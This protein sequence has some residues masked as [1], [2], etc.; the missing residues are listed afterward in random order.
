MFAIQQRLDLAVVVDL[1][2]V[3]EV[4]A[5][6]EGIPEVA[7][8]S[9]RELVEEVANKVTTTTTTVED[10]EVLVGAEDLV[11][12]IMTSHSET[13][14]RLSISNPTGKCWRRLISIVWLS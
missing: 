9:S 2:E 11:G 5:G 6:G 13:A 8:D 12:K 14:M 10:E 4:S 1:P 7:V 3:D